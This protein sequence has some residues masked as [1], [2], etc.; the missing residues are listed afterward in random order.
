MLDEKLAVIRSTRNNIHRYRRLLTTE[1]TDLEQRFVERRLAE[2]TARLDELTA[3][4]F[5][6]TF[7]LPLGDRPATAG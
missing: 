1:L 6:L 7:N 2:E 5:P 3:S 4:T